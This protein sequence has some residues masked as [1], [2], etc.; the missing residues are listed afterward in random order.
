MKKRIIGREYE[1]M[2]CDK[3]G[4]DMIIKIILEVFDESI[5]N[6]KTFHFCGLGCLSKFI[7]E[8]LKVIE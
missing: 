4:K 7:L 3:C 2:E 5:K 6:W 8:D 1:I